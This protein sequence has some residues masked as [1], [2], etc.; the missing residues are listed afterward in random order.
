MEKG[1]SE[2]VKTLRHEPAVLMLGKKGLT[3]DFIK[4]VE[5]QLK[6]K[7]VIKIRVLKSMLAEKSVDELASAIAIKTNSQLLETRGHTILLAKRHL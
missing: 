2:I 5:R 1:Y 4:E 7:K 3:E 6:G